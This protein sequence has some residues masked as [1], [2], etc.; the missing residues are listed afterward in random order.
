MMKVSFIGLGIMG[1][2]MAKNLLKAGIDLT[3][4]N[5]SAAAAIELEKAGA[6]RAKSIVE[7]TK[8]ADV[9][10]TMLANPEV[11]QSVMLGAGKGLENMSPTSI[12]L[13]ASTVNPS[14]SLHCA[15]QAKKQQVR[16]LD[17]PVAGTKPH[18]ENAELTFFVGGEATNLEVVQTLLKQMG[19]KVLHIGEIGKGA[20]FKMLVNALLAQSMLIF[21]ETVLLGEKMGLDKDFLLNTLPNLVVS[22]PFTKAKASM[23]KS[24]NYEVQFPL[25]LMHKDLHLASLCAYENGQPLYLANIA[26]EIYAAA[27]QVG[28]GRLDFAAVH[29]YLEET[30]T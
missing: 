5:R 25:E 9:V 28:M 19:Q 8:S 20:S 14:F 12:W 1:S 4:Y 26:K 13:D 7:A 16:F 10:I 21:S 27:K 23:I 29:Q 18:A 17:T 24:E 22:A 15:E 30:R 6:K 11:V 2:R 3:V